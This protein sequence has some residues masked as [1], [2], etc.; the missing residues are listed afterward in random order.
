MRKVGF[1]MNKNYTI[2]QMAET[3]WFFNF[4]DANE[5]GEKITVELSKCSNPHCNNS[6]PNLWYKMVI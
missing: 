2:E 5:K 4:T 6:L 1:I 3:R